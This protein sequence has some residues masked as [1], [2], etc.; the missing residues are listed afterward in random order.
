MKYLLSKILVVSVFAVTSFAHASGMQPD[1]S[2]VLVDAGV[3]EGTIN[4]TN[5]SSQTMLLYTEIKNVPEDQEELLIV[6][7]PISRVE[8]REKQLV[9]FIFQSDRPLLTQRLKR[10]IFEGIP[11]NSEKG[12]NQLNMTVSQN[13]P[14]IISPANL[15]VNNQPWKLLKW[16]L[17]DKIIR[18]SNDSPYVVRFNKSFKLI[19]IDVDLE[20]PRTYMLP[21]QVD[22]IQVPSGTQV[23]SDI[24]IRFNPASIYGYQGVS[25]EASLVY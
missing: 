22:E 14:I 9:R 23:S 24:K 11:P 13:L 25:Y 3:G 17:N 8:G 1:T 2:V 7:S 6:T 19:T 20:F 10:V 15:P 16:E 5:T 12:K 18:V 4:V 21:G